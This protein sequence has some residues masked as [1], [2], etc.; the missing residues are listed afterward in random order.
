[1][2]QSVAFLLNMFGEAFYR[3]S[4]DVNDPRWQEWAW[5]VVLIA[6]D[7][8]QSLDTL[9]RKALRAGYT[10][11]A[12]PFP[13]GVLVSAFYSAPCWAPPPAEI[14]GKMHS[15]LRRDPEQPAQNG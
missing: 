1:M 4:R 6:H 14:V 7:D 9:R 13:R 2:T 12:T 5:V 11:V 10:L 8:T 3:H 15:N